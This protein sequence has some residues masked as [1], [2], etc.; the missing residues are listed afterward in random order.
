[1]QIK[2]KPIPKKELGS[3]PFFI[4]EN[5]SFYQAT[6]FQTPVIFVEDIDLGNFSVKQTENNLTKIANVTS[7]KAILLLHEMKGIHRRRLVEKRINFVLPGKQMFLPEFLIDLQENFPVKQK[8]KQVLLPSAQLIVLYRILKQ[9][10]RI[11]DISFKDLA[12]LLGYT[13]M[14]ISYAAE[15]LIYHEICTVTGEGE[16]NFKFN[17]IIPEMWHELEQQKLLINPVLK[18]VYVDEIMT[19]PFLLKCS[20]SALPEYSDMNPERQQ[21]YAID[22]NQYYKLRRNGALIN[23]NEDEGKICLEVWKYGPE[24]LA[25]IMFNEDSVVDPLS[26]YLS[27]KDTQ[28]E[29]VEMALEKIIETYIW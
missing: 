12:D 10:N 29:R 20:Y 14:T 8:E 25:E 19:K 11:E 7:K 17:L 23:E 9:N 6:L 27:L 3:L 28:D 21:Y 24:I 2:C 4:V 16:K 1:M 13:A 5:Y 15:N 26:L 18:K 22:K